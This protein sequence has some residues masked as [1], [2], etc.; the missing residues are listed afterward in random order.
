MQG[1]C[2]VFGA[3]WN[4][5]DGE[6]RKACVGSPPDRKDCAARL[7]LL[8]KKGAGYGTGHA[9]YEGM[10]IL[11]GTD[12]S[13]S[14]QWACRVAV[15]LARRFGD[16]IVLVHAFHPP[17]APIDLPVTWGSMVADWRGQLEASLAKQ[18]AELRSGGIH[19]EEV[20]VDGF[21]DHEVANPFK[22][23]I[24]GGNAF[25]MVVSH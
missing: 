17:Q 9:F 7:R 14:S 6:G 15:Q 1:A 10:P 2:E 24:V 19:V 22:V 25:E 5:A 3:E 13:S 4:R 11:C 20:F 8:Y 18:A 23:R 16:S 12:F 21:P